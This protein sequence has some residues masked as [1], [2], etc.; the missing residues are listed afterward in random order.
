MI[1]KSSKLNSSTI[2]SCFF[3]GQQILTDLNCI[4]NWAF[5]QN[6]TQPRYRPTELLFNIYT[7]QKRNSRKERRERCYFGTLVPAIQRSRTLRFTASRLRSSPLVRVVLSPFLV[8]ERSYLFLFNHSHTS[9]C[10][11]VEKM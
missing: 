4:D 5:N 10:L 9:C 11:V 2:L 7:F 1:F 8:D 3:F 6:R